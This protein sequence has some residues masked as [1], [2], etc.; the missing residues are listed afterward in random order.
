MPTEVMPVLTP[1]LLEI[2]ALSWN[3]SDPSY[4]MSLVTAVRTSN[5]PVD[6]I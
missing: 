4:T 3:V 6:G 5:V 1:L 2:T